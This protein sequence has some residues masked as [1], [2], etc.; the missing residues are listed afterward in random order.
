LGAEMK[1]P[2]RIS[3]WCVAD[4]EDRVWA[5][6]N[7]EAAR[8]DA[9]LVPGRRV[10]HLVELTEAESWVLSRSREFASARAVGS[11]LLAE[12]A[13]LLVARRVRCRR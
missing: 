5:M 8:R 4:N 6:A 7:R 13:L 1:K 3:W 11:S 2:K 10:V 9:N 12:E